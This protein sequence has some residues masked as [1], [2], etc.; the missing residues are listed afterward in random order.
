MQRL[1]A[2]ILIL[3]LVTEPFLFTAWAQENKPAEEHDAA[4]EWPQEIKKGGATIVVYQP[5]P[6]SFEGTKL[7]G[8]AA[9]SVVPP[10]EKEPVFGAVWIE[11][12]VSTDRD[13][14]LVYLEDLKIPRVRFPNASEDKQKKLAQVLEKEM[15]SWAPEISLDR[16]MT[17]LDTAEVRQ[18]QAEQLKNDPPKIRVVTEPTELVIID[19]KPELRPVEN[20]KL[21]RVINSLYLIVLDGATKQYYL[22]LDQLWMKSAELKTGGWKVEPNPPAEV[23]AMTPKPDPELKSEKGIVPKV[24]VVDKAEEMITCDG[25]PKYTPVAGNELLYMTN[26]EASVFVELA[27][28]QK[29]VLLSGRWFNAKSLDGPWAYVPAN[30]LPKAFAKIP[31]GSEVGDVRAFVAGTDEA[32]DAVMDAQIPQT[33]AIKREKP[34]LKVEYDG[35]PQFQHIDGTNHIGFAINCNTSVLRDNRAAKPVFYCCHEGVWYVANSPLG[36]W[37]VATAVPDEIYK[38]PPSCPVYNVTYVK[39]YKVTPEVVYVGYLPGY[40]GC[41][42]YGGTV[43]YGTGYSYV[44]WVGTV[45]Y[46]PPY[47]YGYSYRYSSALG[48]WFSPVS[49]GGVVR[50]TRRR[51]RR[52]VN[53]RN[54]NHYKSHHHHH[55]HHNNR[56]NNNK[57]RSS[58]N[59][60]RNQGQANRKQNANRNKQANRKNNHY[61]DKKGNVHRKDNKGNW[62]Q[63]NKSGWSNSNKSNKSSSMSRESQNRNRGNSRTSSY[64]K[65]KSSSS[66][67]R[68]GG[69]RG[70]GGRRR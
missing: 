8:R 48:R 7:T 1:L 23:K 49:V 42:V 20:T 3:A 10:G 70:G 61:A 16:L 39:V 54:N 26:T 2:L 59:R 11:A 41:Y 19:G 34:S 31:E 53:Y 36:P 29:Y 5:Q 25:E 65:S 56:Y 27:T 47:T 40:T 69:S 30:K 60:N 9:V 18:R 15:L 62:Q 55:H 52:R 68:S 64:N 24:I 51:T 14:R 28:Q 45:Y 38:I 66:R 12:R 37:A 67:S 58:Q 4:L 57:N 17:S 63:K 35:N 43:V 46:P 33:A 22:N 50:R 6:E 13:A 32:K 44:V 21:M